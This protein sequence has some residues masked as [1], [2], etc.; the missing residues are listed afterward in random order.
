MILGLILWYCFFKSG[1]HATIA[2][3]LLALAIPAKRRITSKDSFIETGR[4]SLHEFHFTKQTQRKYFLTTDQSHSV[5]NIVYACNKVSSPLQ[6]LEHVLHPFVAFFIMPIFALANAGIKIE[7]DFLH[8]VI[9]PV[10]LS[11]MLGLFFGKQIGI[12]LF[13]WI[14]FKLKLGVL[15]P[16]L[17]WKHIYGMSCLA[18]IGFTMSL[19]I[20]NL[21]FTDF[22]HIQLA[23]IGTLTGSLISSIFG[24]FILM[25]VKPV[26]L[27][28]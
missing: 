24:V 3:V 25:K 21:A 5:D 23:K 15:P 28:K 17:S 12:M 6:R 26:P 1:I 16:D 7:G 11:V 20:A 2:G 8:S 19:F 27:I 18:G 22:N 10:S 9:S 13:T 14:G 4:L